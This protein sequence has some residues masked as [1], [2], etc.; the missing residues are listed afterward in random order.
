MS[1]IHVVSYTHMH[2]NVFPNN[3]RRW[4]PDS[5]YL[6]NITC[7]KQSKK[8]NQILKQEQQGNKAFCDNAMKPEHSLY[9]YIGTYKMAYAWQPRGHWFNSVISP[10]NKTR[11]NRVMQIKSQKDISLGFSF[12]TK[13]KRMSQNILLSWA[14]FNFVTIACSSKTPN[15][16][17]IV[18]NFVVK[19]KEKFP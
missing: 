1:K 12:A 8:D 6:A 18:F 2:I 14:C 17:L 9:T 16:I 4:G 3:L 5:S 19:R 11:K 10:R 15:I 7:N 13:G